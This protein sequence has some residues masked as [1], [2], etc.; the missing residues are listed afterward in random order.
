MHFGKEEIDI[1][2]LLEIVAKSNIARSSKDK[3]LMLNYFK[4]TQFFRDNNLKA[5]EDLMKI[6]SQIH[7]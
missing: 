7:H 3:E 1:K 2:L 6:I 5:K 4:G